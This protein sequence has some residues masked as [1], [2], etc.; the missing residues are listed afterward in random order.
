MKL[1]TKNL[2]I[3]LAIL[4]AGYAVTQLTKRGG[5][6]K[7]LKSE[8]VSLDTAVVSKVEILSTEGN[9][10]LTK[11]DDRWNVTLT[12]GTQKVARQGAV[13]SLL[14]SLNTI[15]PGRLAAKTP[16]KWKDYAVDSTGTR[17]KVYENADLATDIVIGR[18]GME[19]QQ[20]FYSFVRLFEDQEVY[21]AN[22][23]MGMSIGKD[24]ASYRENSVLRLT[25]DSLTSVAF[26]YP[27]SSYTL[28]K[29]TEWYLEDQPADS[30]SVAEYL[31]GLSYTSSRLFFDE[32]I[33]SKPSHTITYSF[34]DRPELI[35]EGF[36]TAQ[37]MVIRSSENE[38]ESFLDP[39]LQKKAFKGR[40]AFATTSE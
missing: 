33:P 37:G 15:K 39:A 12:S 17:V 8:L 30:S 2:L 11:V 3:V 20:R 18:F 1:T 10:S 35:L 25:K 6:S 26:N 13:T 28:T 34:T 29:G 4:L 21:V 31:N 9:V 7:S 36:T 27:D 32:E 24:A 22:D 16:D 38:D 23:F 5:R 19:G 14:N 40:S